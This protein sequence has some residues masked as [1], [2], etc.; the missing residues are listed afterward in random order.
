MNFLKTKIFLGYQSDV[1]NPKM[2]PFIYSK[3][4]IRHFLDFY[5][6]IVYLN[7][8]AQYLKKSVSKE[9]KVLF[10]GTN[11]KLRKVLSE[12]AT[13]CYSFF[14]N[15]RW[16]GGT[17]TNWATIKSQTNTLAYLENIQKTKAYINLTKKEKFSY[18]RKLVQ[19]RLDFTG[20]KNMVELPDI[21]IVIDPKKDLAAILECKKLKIPIISVIDSNDNPDLVDFPIPI[22]TESTRI[23]KLILRILSNSILR[24]YVL[25][26]KSRG[27]K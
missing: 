25:Y 19:L 13:R 9:K 27:K 21:V 6:S 1:L 22:N 4:K 2:K 26:L 14:I 12:E 8:A 7:K 15:Y 24:G 11:K 3:N 18:Y 17:L 23:I 10:I 20:V 16:L 5:K